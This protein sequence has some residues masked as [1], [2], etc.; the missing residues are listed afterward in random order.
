M[1][2]VPDDRFSHF[3]VPGKTDRFAAANVLNRTFE[4]SAPNRKWIAD[5]TYVLSKAKFIG[6]ILLAID[7]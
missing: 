5:F 7:F 1:M 4:A 6:E 2:V 3:A